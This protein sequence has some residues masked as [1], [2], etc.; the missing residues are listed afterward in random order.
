MYKINMKKFSKKIIVSII[1]FIILLNNINFNMFKILATSVL[2][3]GS[4]NAS[5]IT[6]TVN[7]PRLLPGMTAV[8]VEENRIV[9]IK[10]P[11]LNKDNWYNY[12]NNIWA[13]AK[14]KDGSLWVWIPTFAYKIT[15]YNDENKTSIKGYTANNGY[16]NAN[17]ERVTDFELVKSNYF[18][19]ETKFVTTS[20]SLPNGWQIHPAFYKGDASAGRSQ[21]LSEGFWMSKGLAQ[22][23]QDNMPIFSLNQ[24]NPDYK[25]WFDAYNSLDQLAFSENKY[26]LTGDFAKVNLPRNTEIGSLIYLTL[27]NNM[28][29]SEYSTGNNSGIVLPKKEW[30]SAYVNNQSSNLPNTNSS[31]NAI[32]PGMRDLDEIDKIEKYPYSSKTDATYNEHINELRRNALLFAGDALYEV[33]YPSISQNGANNGGVSI[34]PTG[35]NPFII[36]NG[37]NNIAGYEMA[38]GKETNIGYRAVIYGFPM[39]SDQKVTVTFKTQMGNIYLKGN[40]DNL[41]GDKTRPAVIQITKGSSIVDENRMFEA[42]AENANFR[43]WDKD[44]YGLPIYE[45]LEVEATFVSTNPGSLDAYLV[46]FKDESGYIYKRTHVTQR[47]NAAE[48]ARTI[49]PEKEGYRFVRWDKDVNSPIT[50]DTTFIAIFE[51]INEPTNKYRVRYLNEDDSVFAEY[52]VNANEYASVPTNIPSLENKV[53]IGWTPNPS[54]TLITSNTDFKAIFKFIEDGVESDKVNIRINLDGGTSGV[55]DASK[56]IRINKG[57]KLNDR[58]NLVL[59]TI[60][61]GSHP[62]KQN[63]VFIKWDIDFEKP[64][65]EDTTITAVYE[66]MLYTYE[67]VEYILGEKKILAQG[68]FEAG[69]NLENYEPKNMNKEGYTFIGWS[70]DNTKPQYSNVQFIAMWEYADIKSIIDNKIEVQN[71]DPITIGFDLDGGAWP[72]GVRNPKSSYLVPRG[73]IFTLIPKPE[74]EG[75]EFL[76]WQGN[77]NISLPQIKDTTYKAIWGVKVP[78]ARTLTPNITRTN[79]NTAVTNNISGSTPIYTNGLIRAVGTTTTNNQA[80]QNGVVPVNSQINGTNLRPVENLN[81]INGTNNLTSNS[82]SGVLTNTQ[83]PANVIP[84]A[85]NNEFTRWLLLILIPVL[86]VFITYNVFKY[87]DLKGVSTKRK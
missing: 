83:K 61:T 6:Q 18:K 8:K 58:E 82:L 28:Q 34:Y 38:N 42:Y 35:D 2:P 1:I 50:S 70:N 51:K 27:A 46:I 40:R 7:Q 86:A 84:K 77:E 44:V 68:T 41:Y 45:D 60:L 5:D 43:G 81:G 80:V 36:R 9:D 54:K 78:D 59:Y 29:N 16:Y 65:N 87:R 13:N 74:K 32:V 23:S 24:T 3:T 11:L 47:E 37:I 79:N 12:S 85:G 55:F 19:I 17:N 22:K 71:I 76:R 26:G 63:H 49:T 10:E 39:I 30:T 72:S 67:Y 57:S 31:A 64:I 4:Q 52:Q 14:T 48:I 75:Y 56:I 15:Y 66:K 21:V 62:S 20:T 53:F 33:T 25:N 69:T 73:M